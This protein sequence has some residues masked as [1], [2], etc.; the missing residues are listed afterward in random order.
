MINSKDN[1]IE[2]PWAAFPEIPPGDYFWREAGEHW[3]DEIWAPYWKSLTYE[4]R[5]NYLDKWNVPVVW[6]CYCPQIN[7]HWDNFLKEG[8]ADSLEEIPD[9]PE[10]DYQK[11]LEELDLYYKRALAKEARN[12]K[13]LM[14][15]CI[16]IYIVSIPFS[17]WIIHKMHQINPGFSSEFLFALNLSFPISILFTFWKVRKHYKNQ[18]Y[19]SAKIYCF[20]PVLILIIISICN[21]II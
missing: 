13:R 5:K 7:P 11:A 21:F 8:Q 1:E 12:A 10:S 17:I 19:E 3:Y 14:L 6:K 18:D 9:L 4:E 2:P 20:L 15:I 16:P